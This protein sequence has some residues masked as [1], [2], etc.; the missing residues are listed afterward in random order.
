MDQVYNILKSLVDPVFIIFILLLVCLFMCL[1]KGKNKNITLFLFFIIILLYTSSTSPVSNYLSY[2]LEK[3]YI[4]KNS[5][6]N[7]IKPDVIVVLGGGVHEIADLNESFLADATASRLIHAVKMFKYY[8][9]NYL[10]CSGN[11]LGKISNAEL[12]AKTAEELGVPRENIRIEPKSANT[13][14]HAVEFNRMFSDKNIKIGLVTSASH[15][16][17]SEKEFRKY[18]KN[19]LAMP[20]G[21]LYGSPMNNSVLDYLPQS[22]CLSN[23]VYIIHEYIGQLWYSLK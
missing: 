7:K 8:G 3:D 2:Q 9:A 23:N 19:V 4:N 17:R 21:Y 10:V 5:F 12:M 22:H 1:I 15:M 6:D 13:Y 11:G 20:S 14:E 16:K 18:F